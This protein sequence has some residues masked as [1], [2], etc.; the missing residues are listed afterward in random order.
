LTNRGGIGKIEKSGDL[1]LEAPD[2]GKT[3]ERNFTR[4]EKTN[5]RG[6]EQL[7]QNGRSQ[8]KKGKLSLASKNIARAAKDLSVV[9]D[10]RAER[11]G[12]LRKKGESKLVGGDK[13]RGGK[14]V[15]F[16]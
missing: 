9:R 8:K 15:S 10:P 1:E 16:S 2:F 4:A 11:K 3:K 7:K 12:T 13:S 14:T 6:A 5:R